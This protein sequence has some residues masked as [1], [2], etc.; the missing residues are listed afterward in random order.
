MST[1]KETT[2]KALV[3]Q[4]SEQLYKKL[5]DGKLFGTSIEMAVE[6]LTERKAKGKFDGDLSKFSNGKSSDVKVEKTEKVP[7]EKKGPKVKEEKVVKE[8]K[9]SKLSLAYPDFKLKFKKGQEVKF[10]PF[11]SEKELKGVVVGSY[12]WAPKKG[13]VRED[14]RIRVGD[15]TY[16]KKGSEITLVK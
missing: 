16:V 15:K 8:K 9:S 1:L 12:P 7:V 6:I 4:T 14:V 3:S 10:T 2:R 5:T 13:E 11:R